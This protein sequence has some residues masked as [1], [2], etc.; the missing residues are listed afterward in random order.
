MTPSV[1]GGTVASS[2]RNEREA[3]MNA[4]P[5]FLR[6]ILLAM[7]ASSFLMGAA[8]AAGITGSG[9][10]ASEGRPVSAF[11]AIVLKGPMQLVLRQAA[12]EAVE[13]RADDNLL[14]LVETTVNG[15]TLEIAARRGASYTTRNSIV[16][17]VDV[18][19]LKELALV[20]TGDATG[21]GL[22][23]G[24]LK[25]R[26]EGAG[27]LR[28]RQLS[29]DALAINVSGSGDVTVS[30][31]TGKLGVSIAGSGDV[32]TRELE[33]DEVS[34]NIAGS[35]DAHVNARKTLAVAIAGSGD[36]DYT[37]EASV[38]TSIAGSGTVQKR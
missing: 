13:V 31:R 25:V 24:E 23:A 21:D 9:K 22:K 19:T 29:A 35:G 8:A 10:V 33:A 28:L 4:V 38:R 17:T 34:V 20:G 27:D 16:V 5:R 32:A 11:Q 2:P 7:L 36:V 37:G 6:R 26:I 14:Q 3:A 15:G 18:V 1:K 30:G 12:K